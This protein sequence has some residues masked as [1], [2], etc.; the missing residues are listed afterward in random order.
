MIGRDG[1]ALEGR[2][3]GW[4]LRSWWVRRGISAKLMSAR[5]RQRVQTIHVI[6]P[7]WK[8]RADFGVKSLCQKPVRKKC[9]PKRSGWPITSSL[10]RF[11]KFTSWLNRWAEKSPAEAGPSVVVPRSRSRIVVKNSL[12]AMT[13]RILG[14]VTGA[15][16]DEGA[17]VLSMRSSAFRWPRGHFARRP[18]ETTF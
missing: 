8:P 15:K 10:R 1:P 4:G 5:S 11:L 9:V 2:R 17:H 14:K 18:N 3:G 6:A 7:V 13:N 12:I 16:G